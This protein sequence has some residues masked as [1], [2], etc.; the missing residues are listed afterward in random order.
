M[1]TKI[2]KAAANARRREAE[3][4]AAASEASRLAAEAERLEAEAEKA[5]DEKRKAE[6][7]AEAY[8]RAILDSA[9]LPKTISRR[10]WSNE[11][12]AIA[13][14]WDQHGFALGLS[15]S[16]LICLCQCLPGTDWNIWFENH[17]ESLKAESRKLNQR[18]PFDWKVWKWFRDAAGPTEIKACVLG[19]A[20]EIF[21]DD[22][23]GLIKSLHALHLQ[24]SHDSA[25]TPRHATPTNPLKR[26]HSESES[27]LTHSG[28][29]GTVAGSCVGSTPTLLEP[30][31]SPHPTENFDPDRHSDAGRQRQDLPNA[32][33]SP[34][35]Y[36][37]FAA[38]APSPH[39]LRAQ[40]KHSGTGH[41]ASHTPDVPGYNPGRPFP[42]PDSHPEP[43]SAPGSSNANLGQGSGA[44]TPIQQ[45]SSAPA[46]PSHP[47]QS[48]V[49]DVP[50]VLPGTDNAPHTSYN[51][52][53][54]SGLAYSANAVSPGHNF[55]AG[56]ERLQSQNWA[57]TASS[58]H[59]APPSPMQIASLLTKDG[60]LG[61]A[62]PQ[63]PLYKGGPS[64]QTPQGA[65]PRPAK[66]YEI[67]QNLV[68]RT[69]HVSI[70]AGTATFRLVIPEVDKP[71]LTVTVFIHE[72]YRDY[73]LN[74]PTTREMPQ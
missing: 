12:K 43:R 55:D 10:N 60:P 67:D 34:S 4:K 63:T 35:A 64:D 74:Q 47:A 13:N 44:D 30:K 25:A 11:A 54:P 19:L 48:T 72:S 27:G 56:T 46:P 62:L 24:Q 33:P 9:T 1:H 68:D 15:F 73:I 28:S 26:K 8:L 71:F 69:T 23:P 32:A 22:L 31:P 16:A 2:E 39:A 61:E 17:Q 3:A 51:P 42:H 53:F 66:F 18:F 29:S 37:A 52:G 36:Q 41:N 14:H 57:A 6:E 59:Q 65:N 21:A 7:E 50:P 20:Y 40:P 38:H 49:H 5:R 45:P 70:L 58:Y